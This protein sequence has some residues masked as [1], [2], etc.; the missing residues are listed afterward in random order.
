MVIEAA[1]GGNDFV[2]ATVDYT[3][4]ENHNIEVLSMLG[5]GLTGTG[6]AGSDT[7]VQL[8]AGPTHWSGLAAMM[9]ITSTTASRCGD[10][11]ANA[12]NERCFL[13]TVSYTLPA[14]VEVLYVNGSELTGTGSSSADT[15]VTSRSEHPDWRQRQRQLRVL[16]RQRQ[17]A[18][19]ADFDHSQVS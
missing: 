14:N 1:N 19:V 18:S 10:R 9:S 17:R 4:S 6:T 16:R 11:G 5:S 7:S 13:A 3:L 2:G 15:L 12:G 8:S